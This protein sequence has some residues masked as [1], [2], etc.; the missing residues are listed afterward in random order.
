[1]TKLKVFLLLIC[2]LLA[3]C[4][5]AQRPISEV[6][7]TN[8]PDTAVTSPPEQT[9]PAN[10][11]PPNP[12]SAKPDDAKL[13]RQKAFVQ[14]SDVVIRESYPPQISVN[15]SGDLPTPCNQLRVDIGKPTSDN[16]INIDVYSVID[17]NIMCT[18][19][20]QPFEESISMGVFPA[21]H[22]SVFVNGE[23]AGEFDS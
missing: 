6:G 16:K 5:P 15:L 13:V 14:E 10:E 17:P 7:T 2:V 22:Y 1:M 9:M 3:A 23:L 4:V 20:V 18:E 21:G 11:P 8:P 19:V 12:F